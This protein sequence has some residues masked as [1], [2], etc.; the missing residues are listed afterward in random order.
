VRY[1]P[2]DTLRFDYRGPF[3]RS[4]SAVIVRAEPVWAEPPG[5]FESLV[6]VAPI[7]WAALGIVM[8]PGESATLLGRDEPRW[9]AWRYVQGEEA[10]D[11]VY[12]RGPAPQLA[13]EVRRGERVA[14]VVEVE[15]ASPGPRPTRAVMRFSGGSSLTFTVQAL[16]SVAPYPPD[17]WQR[18]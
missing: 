12:Q 1:A 10:I 15:L 13:A 9:R 6:P 18:S 11:F 17:T 8:P 5:D 14:G 7:L 16:D 4:G 3:G 2:P